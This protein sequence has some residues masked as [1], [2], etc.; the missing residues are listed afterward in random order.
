MFLEMQRHKRM[1]FTKV[2]YSLVI[3]VYC[4][5]KFLV[6]EAF[7]VTVAMLTIDLRT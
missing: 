6:A 4:K 1:S 2:I 7:T 3:I 5:Y